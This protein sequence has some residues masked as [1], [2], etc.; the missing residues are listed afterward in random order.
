VLE[1]VDH[2]DFRVG[3]LDLLDHDF[4]LVDLDSPGLFVEGHLDVH[5]VAVLLGHG[6][7]NGFF[8]GVDQHF[9]VDAFVLADLVDGFLE[10]QIHERPPF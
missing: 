9:T 1:G 2:E 8:Q 6:G 10:F 4:E 7:P 3:I 5:L